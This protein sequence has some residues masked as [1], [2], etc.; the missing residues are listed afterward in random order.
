MTRQEIKAR[1]KAQLGN[2]IFGSAWLLALVVCLIQSLPGAVPSIG[3]I[4]VLVLG[5]PLAYGVAYCFLKQSRDGQPMNIGDMFK[6]FTDDFLGTFLLGLLSSL[7]IALWSLLLVIPGIVKSYAYAMAYYI[8]VDHPEYDW[9]Q[10]LSTS[11]QMMNGHKMDLFVQD[12]SFI[13]WFLVGSLCLG[14]GVLW[15]VPYRTASYAQ[16]YESLKAA[17]PVVEQPAVEA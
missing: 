2:N 1:A 6:G 11:Q 9:K 5:G 8:K 3:T 7:F 15:V 4:L 14:V 16:F 12:L 17:T 13:G 10:C